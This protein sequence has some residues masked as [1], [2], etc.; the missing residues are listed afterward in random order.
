[1]KNDRYTVFVSRSGRCD[2]ISYQLWVDTTDKEKFEKACAAAKPYG[3]KIAKIY[4][5]DTE[6]STPDF[7]GTINK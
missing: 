2:D 5:P 6:L 1:M 7:V 3:W 4:Y